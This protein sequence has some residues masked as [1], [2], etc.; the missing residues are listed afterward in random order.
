[1]LRDAKYRA[2]R[3]GIPFAITA[4]DVKMPTRC[5]ILGIPIK[6]KTGNGPGPAPNSPSLDRIDPD[7]SIG[8]IQSNCWIV[9]SRANTLKNNGTLEELAAI[10]RW[11]K[12]RLRERRT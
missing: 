7:P 3:D 12:R 11:A 1:M 4:A 8:Y 5:P 6:P 2:K 9:S 10:G